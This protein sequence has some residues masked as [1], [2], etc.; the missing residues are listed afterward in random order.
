MESASSDAER[1]RRSAEDAYERFKSAKE[2]YESCRRWDRDDCDRRRW[3][4][5]SARS[6]AESEISTFN[7]RLRSLSGNA[8]DVKSACAVEGPE[9]STAVRVCR[10]VRA[11]KPR[12][13]Q[14]ALDFCRKVRFPEEQ[15]R[16]CMQE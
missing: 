3:D 12:S 15:C 8:E 9:V 4:A 6:S 7:S 5:E 2:D 10:L 16:R 11:L 14:E 13:E 1:A